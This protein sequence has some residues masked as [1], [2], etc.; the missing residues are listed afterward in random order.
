[1]CNVVNK[2]KAPF[3]V[4]I[5]RGSIWGN[6]YSITKQHDRNQVI[7]LYRVY[8]WNCIHSGDVTIADLHAL[9]GKTLGCF[10]KPQPC[11]G[12]IIVKAVAWAMTQPIEPTPTFE[13]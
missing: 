11:H 12:D 3:D 2:Y 9:N 4:Y 10:C 5:G 7:G 6:P 1:M 8:L 13:F